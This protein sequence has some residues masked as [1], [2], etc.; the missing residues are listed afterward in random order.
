MDSV[1][2]LPAGAW[3]AGRQ[4]QASVQ[5]GN[6]GNGNLLVESSCDS[7][8]RRCWY[9]EE[10]VTRIRNEWQEKA[11]RPPEV[12]VHE[13]SGWQWFWMRTGQILTAACCL[14]IIGIRIKQRLKRK[15]LWH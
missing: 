8:Q 3:Y 7:I 13:P 10:E 9:L 14:V 4:G 6:D 11:G 15:G 1:A 12:I 2:K 5:A